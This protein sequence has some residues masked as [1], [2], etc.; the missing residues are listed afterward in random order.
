M[1]II[2]NFS[3]YSDLSG[4]KYQDYEQPSKLE[5]NNLVNK[6]F[7][8]PYVFIVI[9]GGM[10]DLKALYGE[11]NQCVLYMEQLRKDEQIAQIKKI[12]DKTQRKAVFIGRSDTVS[13]LQLIKREFPGLVQLKTN[14]DTG[15]W[16]VWYDK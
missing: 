16:F 1:A 2:I 8:G 11:K 4:L 7:S 5:I 3:L 9:D 12:L 13:D 6:K 15:K 14:F 10:Y